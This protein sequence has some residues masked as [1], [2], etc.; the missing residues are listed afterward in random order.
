M[1]KVL[2]LLAVLTVF[3]FNLAANDIEPENQS[4]LYVKT[5]HIE[6]IYSHLLGYKITFL[7]AGLQY[8]EF[9]VPLEW[10]R[11]RTDDGK[12]RA[13]MVSGNDGAFPYFSV[14]YENG[15]FSHI[16]LYV[17]E[18]EGHSSWGNM[19]SNGTTDAYFDIETLEIEY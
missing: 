7:S 16:R 17:Y 12:M 4:V 8:K 15:T 9:Y 13:E 14:F 19:T 3:S 18:D 11:T 1:K 5:M 6:K 10:F 2:I